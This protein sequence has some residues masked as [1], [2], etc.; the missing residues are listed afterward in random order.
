MRFAVLAVAA[1]TFWGPI[2]VSG[3]SV[4]LPSAEELMGTGIHADACALIAAYSTALGDADMRGFE[5]YA[6]KVRLCSSH[7]DRAV[8]E[9]TLKFA[10]AKNRYPKDI[11]ACTGG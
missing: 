10:T 11:F 3:Q 6:E 5:G 4:R 2:P 7:P 8:C 1:A 9:D